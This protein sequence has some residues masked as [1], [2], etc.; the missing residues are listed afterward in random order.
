[1]ASASLAGVRRRRRALDADR[2][3]SVSNC[4]RTETS[5]LPGWTNTVPCSAAGMFHSRPWKTRVS[6]SASRAST[7]VRVDL[8]HTDLGVVRCCRG[9]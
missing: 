4:L 9:R 2:R 1:M 3:R 8:L 5:F 6:L 7:D